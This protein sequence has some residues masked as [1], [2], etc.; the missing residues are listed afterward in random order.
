MNPAS[1]IRVAVLMGGP[2][3]E[4]DVSLETGRTICRNL[5]RDRYEVLP[6]EITADLRWILH[7]P[8]WLEKGRGLKD[9]VGAGGTPG[10]LSRELEAD[11]AAYVRVDALRHDHPVDV[12]FIAMHGPFGEDGTVQGLLEG[13]G[14]PYTG[15]GVLASALAMDKIQSKV[16][17][18]HY[19]IPTPDWIDVPRRRWEE[20]REG[21]RRAVAEQVG[22]PCVPKPN[23]SGSSIGIRIVRDAG[24]L[25]D[26]LDAAFAVAERVLVEKAVAGVE[27]T[28]GV[29]GTTGG[30]SEALPVTEIVPPDGEFFDYHNKYS[31]RTQ[32]ICPARIPEAAARQARE[33]AVRTHDVLGCVGFSRTDFILTGDG[34]TVLELNS[35]PGLTEVS[36][37]PQQAKAAGIEFPKLLDRIIALALER[38]ATP[39]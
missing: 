5:D 34:L 39:G 10:G 22:F 37:L 13:I 1:K 35:I 6:I 11:D 2:S 12:A 24:D 31:G 26:A 36:L 17:L 16:I 8:D 19:G 23:N 33:L 14:V 15:S 28:C 7:A 18:R 27:L 4:R 30:G 3:E 25:A 21:V 9:V 20:D 32:E 29:L 38:W